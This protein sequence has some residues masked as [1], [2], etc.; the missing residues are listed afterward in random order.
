MNSPTGLQGGKK[1][2]AKTAWSL[3]KTPYKLGKVIGL[4]EWCGGMAGA[5][6]YLP[7]L[8]LSKIFSNG[9]S[10]KLLLARKGFA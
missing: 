3:A 6:L 8:M 10:T 2:L 5:A 4:G 9:P 7:E 1:I